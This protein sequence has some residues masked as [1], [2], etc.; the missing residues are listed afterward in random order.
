MAFAPDAA[1]RARLLQLHRSE[2]RHRRRALHADGRRR[3]CWPIRRRA[4]TCAGRAAS[5]FI[6]QP[7]ANHNGGHLAF[8]P[9][10]YLYI[11]LGDGG[12]GNDPQN[13]AQNP[14]TLLGKMLRIDVDVADG[15]PTGYRVPP[16]NPFLDGSRSPA[17]GE[18]WAFGLRNP[19]RYS[20]D[21]FGAGAT[22]ALLIGDVGQGAREEINYE[23]RGAGGRNYGWRLRE[24]RIATPG[25]PATT[26]GVLPLVDPLFDYDRG[27]SA[28]RSPAATSIAAARSAAAYR[29]RYFFA[30]FVDARA[31]GRSACRVNRRTGEAAV[32]DVVEHTAELGGLA[33]RHRLVRAR[34]RRRALS[35][36]VQRPRPEDRRAASPALP[37]PPPNLSA[38]VS[39]STVTCQWTP[40]APAPCPPAIGSRPARPP[41]RRISA[42]SRPTARR[43]R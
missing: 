24:G 8:G 20:F 18:I 21:D 27:R 4:S 29:G 35:A 38:V 40:P 19:W 11:G 6:R 16:D 5:A 34:L 10:G 33:R 41:A 31:S 7:F 36:D 30:D 37:N 12:S 9:D 28:R 22:G 39:G 43:R 15:D 14:T 25:V 23:P 17:L 1:E 13:N 42:S 32:A 2:R 3:R 26:A